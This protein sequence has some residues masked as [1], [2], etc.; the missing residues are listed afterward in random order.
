MNSRSEYDL[1]FLQVVSR[2]FNWNVS[3]QKRDF[4]ILVSQI[5]SVWDKV[6][7]ITD[8]LHPH[9]LFCPARWRQ[10]IIYWQE[11]NK[12]EKFWEYWWNWKKITNGI[13]MKKSEKFEKILNMINWKDWK[14]RKMEKYLEI[15]KK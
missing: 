8:T 13:I 10:N 6:Y 11:S 9:A 2:L 14:N 7:I 12:F 3:I 15:V 4:D 5:A 1:F